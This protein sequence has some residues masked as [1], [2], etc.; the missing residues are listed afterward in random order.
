[1]VKDKL[2]KIIDKVKD[3]F[4]INGSVIIGNPDN[5]GDIGND[6]VVINPKD[7]EKMLR[8]SESVCLGKHARVEGNGIAIGYG[9]RAK[10]GSIAI[11]NGARAK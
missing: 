6:T 3:K 4:L 7:L 9:A 1:M 10:D 5:I 2:T 11:G 8:R